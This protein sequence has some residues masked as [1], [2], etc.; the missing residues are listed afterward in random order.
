MN[1]KVVCFGEVLWDCFGE[2]K[3]PGGAPMNVALHLRKHGLDSVLISAVGEDE[4]GKR[5]RN[6]LADKEL[7]LFYVQ[8]NTAFSTGSVQ[9][10]LDQSGRATYEIVKP[11]AWD[12]I[13]FKPEQEELVKDADA[14]VFGSLAARE[15]TSRATLL[16][17]LNTARF[18]VFDMNLRPP[19]FTNEVLEELL[20]KTDILKINEDE[21]SYLENQYGLAGQKEAAKLEWLCRKFDLQLVVVTL[22]D[23]G[24]MAWHKGKLVQQ[25]GLKVEVV[26]TVGAGDA[27]L[28]AFIAGILKE[29]KLSRILEEACAA[30]A[31]VASKA[32]ANPE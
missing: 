29:K 12:A 17:L 22:G 9:V 20:H 10:D 6:F 8:T 31:E 28:A 19:H 16:R 2:E 7:D 4:D 14:V 26:D 25:A 18:K 15:A 21:L 5:M 1:K 3:R 30:G 13:G 32:G 24:A 11:V 23:K 27:F